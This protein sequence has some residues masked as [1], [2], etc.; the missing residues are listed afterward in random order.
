MVKTDKTLVDF[1]I[2]AKKKAEDANPN[3]KNIGE[4]DPTLYQPIYGYIVTY[5][6]N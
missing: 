4:L 1:L 6:S 5:S 3:I 2:E